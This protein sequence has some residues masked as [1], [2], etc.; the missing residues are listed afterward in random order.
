MTSPE[1]SETSAAIGILHPGEMGAS[2]GKVLVGRGHR[3]LWTSDGRSDATRRRAD[4]AG[5]DDAGD[6][7]GL[8]GRCGIILSVCPPH[9][10]VDLAR[11]VAAKSFD[12]TYVDANAVSPVTARKVGEIVTGGGARFVDGGIVG[13]P[14]SAGGYT[15]LYLSGSGASDTAGL[16]VGTDVRVTCLGDGVG[17]ASALKMCYAAYTKGT[18]ALI[19]AIRALAASEGIEADLLAEWETSQPPL[20]E[21]STRVDGVSRKAWRFRGEMEE[22]A[23]TFEDAGLPPGFH[24][25]AAD[26]YGRLED[27]KDAPDVSIADV[28]SLLLGKGRGR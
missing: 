10:A 3:V 19:V 28:L 27:L 15:H 16:F 5:M 13:P 17:A 11:E 1:K 18:A 2:L 24:L 6:L 4:E 8:T 20:A 26:V 25:A 12:G 14:A 21:R 22:I 9:A 23:A 7:D